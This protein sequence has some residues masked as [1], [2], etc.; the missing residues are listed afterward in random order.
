M[1]YN[2]FTPRHTATGYL[3]TFF[4]GHDHARL[5]W[6]HEIGRGRWSHAADT[7]MSMAEGQS[8]AVDEDMG[9]QV[10][11]EQRLSCVQVR[12]L[13]LRGVVPAQLTHAPIVYPQP[14]Q[15]LRICANG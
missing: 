4:E 11:S 15:A 3:E 9:G 6:L 2:L 13:L 10:A 8:A 5:S 7:L 12:R 14:G 1:A